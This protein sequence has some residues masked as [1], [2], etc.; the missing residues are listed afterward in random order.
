MQEKRDDLELNALDL[1]L[2]PESADLT[3]ASASRIK[4]HIEGIDLLLSIT[5]KEVKE[6]EDDNTN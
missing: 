3:L 2:H 5:F 4:G 1:V 6:E